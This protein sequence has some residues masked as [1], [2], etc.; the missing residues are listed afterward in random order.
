MEGTGRK[1]KA[2]PLIFGHS[3][4]NHQI[5]AGNGEGQINSLLIEGQGQKNPQ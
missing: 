1:R 5:L 3:R 4:R 2:A